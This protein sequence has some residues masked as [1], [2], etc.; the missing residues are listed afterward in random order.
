MSYQYPDGWN[1]VPGAEGLI[2]GDCTKKV[3]FL[4]LHG[5]PEVRV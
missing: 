3:Q 2:C 4:I 5:I 1:R